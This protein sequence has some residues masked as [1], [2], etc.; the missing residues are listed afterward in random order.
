MVVTNRQTSKSHDIRLLRKGNKPTVDPE[1]VTHLC[2]IED[3]SLVVLIKEIQGFIQCVQPKCYSKKMLADGVFCKNC[4]S[5]MK[6]I[7]YKRHFD[8]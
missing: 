3:T 4:L 5:H 6:T 1:R 8:Q 7:C 2:Q